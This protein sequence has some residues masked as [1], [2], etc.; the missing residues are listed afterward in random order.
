MATT[1]RVGEE[2]VHADGRVARWDGQAWRV[3]SGPTPR[4][5]RQ[6]AGRL[7][8]QEGA[9]LNILRDQARSGEAIERT[10][11]R[12]EGANQRLRPGPWRGTF[13]NAAIPNE[14]G[15]ILDTI[16][17]VVV[18]G[19]ARLTGAITDQNVRD[20][21]E[22]ERARAEGTL[23]RQLE[24]RGVQTESDAARMALAEL[25]AR[26]TTEG[27][28]AVIDQGIVRAQRDQAKAAYYQ[29]WAARFG[30]I[31]GTRNSRGQTVEDAWHQFG[32]EFRR[33]MFANQNQPSGRTTVRRVR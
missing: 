27:N 10:Y 6:G 23:A 24:Q 22:M 5:G 29:Q 2:A 8:P 13:L 18:G 1:P 26:R 4:V 20:Y 3:I 17:S 19:P 32:E 25:S 21:Q 30:G 33:R 28:Q 11:R 16:G 31:N 7:S 14:G 15:G 12:T 9:F